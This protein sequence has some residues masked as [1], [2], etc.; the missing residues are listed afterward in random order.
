MA[1]ASNPTAP[2]TTH[3]PRSADSAA[4]NSP[5]SRRSEAARG[6]PSP[7]T[8]IVR[9]GD[10]ELVN[11]PTAA[12]GAAVAAPSSPSSPGAVH[13]QIVNFSSDLSP[14][15]SATVAASSFVS[16]EDT[17]AES[18]PEG[19]DNSSGSGNAAKKPAWNKPSNGAVEASPV[20]GAVSW[21]PLSESTKAS[22]KSSSTDSLKALSDGSVS[23]LQGSEIASSSSHKQVNNPNPS[24]TPNHVGPTRQK[25]MKRGSGGSNNNV[26]ANGVFPQ[27]PPPQGPV[28]E[29]PPSNFGKS[30]SEH[31]NKETGQKGG[32]GSQSHGGN[33]HHQPQQQRNSYRRGNGGPHHGSYQHGYGGRRDQDRGN[34]DW[35][36]PRNFSGRDTHMQPQRGFPR[37]F[38]Q[39]PPHTTAT[40]IPPPPLPVR[41]FVSPMVYPDVGSPFFYVGH[42]ESLRGVP[43]VPPL[44]PMFFHVPDPQL[45]SKIVNQI[46]YYFSS[47]N[48]IKDTFLRENMDDQGWVPIKLI[49]G[50]KK[51]SFWDG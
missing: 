46:E 5:R 28:V 50:F 17:A 33:D 26:L 10:A 22:P 43:F 36:P 2:P 21:P 31:T 35:N 39:P 47:D 32:F 45:H 6:V 51:V 38:I 49:A 23:L 16:P 9:G 25:S 42:P 11:S 13:G 7:W 4:I 12:S 20:M 14:S 40:F 48:L 1:T 41:P 19:P 34:Q 3:S 44:P 8:Q 29:G 18:Q 37:G 27:P 30:G 24:S 15:K